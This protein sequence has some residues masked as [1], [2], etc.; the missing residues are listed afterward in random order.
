MP[1]DTAID[2]PVVPNHVAIIMDGNGRWARSRGLP[3][4]YGHRRGVEAVRRTVE[5]AADLGISYLTLFGFSTEN[6]KRPTEEVAELLRLLRM[7][8]RGHVAELC[9][10]GVRLRVIG[11]RSR[12]DQDIIDLIG[13][14]ET[15]TASNTRLTLTVALNYG[16]RQ[17]LV[18]ATRRL[19]R[20]ALSAKPDDDTLIDETAIDETAIAR[21][22]FTAELPDPDLIIRTSGEKRISNFLLWQAAYAEL[23]FVDTLWPDFNRLE[24]EQAIGEYGRRERRYG[25]LVSGE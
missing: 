21:N 11:D 15:L 12:F 23:V 2:S 17:E 5:A 3:R 19:I 7:Y 8:L 24:L 16:A 10:N 25:A 13:H 14:A 20:E 22:L 4:P 1:P 18:A 6:W 9:E